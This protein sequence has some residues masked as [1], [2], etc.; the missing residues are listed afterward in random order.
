MQDQPITVVHRVAGSSSTAGATEYLTAATADLSG[1]C[2]WD[3]GSGSTIDW[4][5]D[6]YTV[7]QQGSDG[8]ATYL[9]ANPYSI[10]YLDAG[11][12]QKL[13]LG[14]IALRNKDGK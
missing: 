12:G 4:P 1:T 2:V 7:G 14:E 9:E 3:L 13:N 6:T 10:G 11:H 8:V 5:E